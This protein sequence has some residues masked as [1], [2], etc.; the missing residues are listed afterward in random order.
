M[1]SHIKI[2]F[3]KQD[4]VTMTRK[5]DAYGAEALMQALSSRKDAY[6][7]DLAA[8]TGLQAELV[9]IVVLDV[10]VIPWLSIAMNR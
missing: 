6:I 1:S 4:M 8:G 7:L 2:L 5:A 9:I 3:I 10:H